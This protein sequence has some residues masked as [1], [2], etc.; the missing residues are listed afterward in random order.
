MIT[1]IDVDVGL[2]SVVAVNANSSRKKLTLI[3]VGN[4]IIWLKYANPPGG[5]TVTAAVLDEG[6]RLNPHGGTYPTSS[7]GAFYA[8]CKYSG[9]KLSGYDES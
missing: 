2:S 3:N 4:Y 5:A 9:G 6:I 7:P 8:I 1:F